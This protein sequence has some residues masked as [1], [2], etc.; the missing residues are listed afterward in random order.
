M[1]YAP[2][3]EH[4]LEALAREYDTAAERFGEGTKF[5]ALY[6]GRAAMLRNAN[7]CHDALPE[8]CLLAETENA[9]LKRVAHVA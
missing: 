1:S 9:Q 5:R 6:A 4:E 2:F 3:P 8:R 7:V